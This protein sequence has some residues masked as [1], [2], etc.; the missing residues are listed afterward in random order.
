LTVPRGYI[1]FSSNK[2]MDH[3]IMFKDVSYPEGTPVP[4]AYEDPDPDPPQPGIRVRIPI[5][6]K[7]KLKEPPRVVDIDAISAFDP[8]SDFHRA[9]A[10]RSLD[11][12]MPDLACSAF[13]TRMGDSTE[14]LVTCMVDAVGGATYAVVYG[15]WGDNAPLLLGAMAAPAAGQMV[16][17]SLPVNSPTFQG[18]TW[19]YRWFLTDGQG[20]P[21]RSSDWQELDI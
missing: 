7:M 1:I 10:D 8:R 12:A 13:R 6:N 19:A 15:R 17:F 2:E 9:V 14:R 20:A 21:L 4:L 18:T 5:A 3:A 11:V 16:E